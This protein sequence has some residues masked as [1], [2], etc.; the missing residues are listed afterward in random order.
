[1][2]EADL[3]RFRHL[4]AQIA[5]PDPQDWQWI[6]R[7]MSQRLFGITEVRAKEYALRY[8]G[9]ASKMERTEQ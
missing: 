3:Q 1:M 9:F 4:A 2:T 8:G 7:H 5:G 6:G